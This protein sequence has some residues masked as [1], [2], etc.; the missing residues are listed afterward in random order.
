[1]NWA[2]I[3]CPNAVSL[4]L[5]IFHVRDYLLHAYKQAQNVLTVFIVSSG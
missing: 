3:L 4:S 5:V 2:E 1:M